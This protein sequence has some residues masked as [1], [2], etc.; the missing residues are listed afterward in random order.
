MDYRRDTRES[1]IVFVGNLPFDTTEEQ[2]VVI[3]RQAGP[4]SEFRLVFDRDSGK[5]R[6]Y[7]F[8][9]YAD[10]KIAVS[11]VKNL[12][13]TL[14]SG[15][16]MKLD[17]ADRDVIRRQF[18]TDGLTISGGTGGLSANPENFEHNGHGAQSSASST[19]AK[20]VGP[21]QVHQLVG[22]LNDQQKAELIAQFKTFAQRNLRVARAELVENPALAHALVDTLVSLNLADRNTL[23]RTKNN[24]IGR[25]HH[26]AP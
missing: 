25:N 19:S 11:A 4:V 20:I 24:G 23:M 18:G 15:R 26:A 2:L 17:F 14:V 9:E 8:C 7:G 5:Q 3:L 13:G 6:G 10:S 12:N 16:P 1:H 22:S 21:E